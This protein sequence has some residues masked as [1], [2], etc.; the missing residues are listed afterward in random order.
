MV[1]YRLNLYV[2]CPENLGGNVAEWV[3]D[4]YAIPE[5]NSPQ[6]IDPM[7]LQQGDKE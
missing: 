1:L 4:A 5:A 3:H 7:G 6:Q 2:R